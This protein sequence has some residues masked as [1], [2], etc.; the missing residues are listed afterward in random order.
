MRTV[1]TT[2]FY[3]RALALALLAA[4]ACD[5]GEGVPRE[6]NAGGAVAESSIAIVGFEGLE[7]ALA[8]RRGGGLLLNFWAMWC[9]P[10]VAELPELVEV[11]RAYRERGG[12]VVGVSYDLMIPDTDPDTIEA[13]VREFLDTRS[14]A[15]SVLVYDEDDYE[16]IN[17]RFALPGDIP[18]TLAIDAQ[19]RI[20]DR[21]EGRAGKE[22]F[23]EMM[24]KALGL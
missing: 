18:V 10:C 14:L 5:T 23:E 7:A 4:L 15:F 17:A 16:A 22:R 19:G 20:V 11:A 1:L 6:G 24:R 2:G 21:Q 3:R 8:A 9:P 12:A 13:T